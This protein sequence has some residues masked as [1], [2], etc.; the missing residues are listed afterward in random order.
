MCTERVVGCHSAC[1]SYK[2]FREKFYEN[3]RIEKAA[4][5]KM[6]AGWVRKDD[7]IYE[8][9]KNSKRW[10]SEKRRLKTGR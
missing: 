4:K 7:F 1:Q 9:S 6:Y 2:E 8:S 5:E 3:K 10:H